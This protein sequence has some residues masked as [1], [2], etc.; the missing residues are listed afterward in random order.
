[1]EHQATDTSLTSSDAPSGGWYAL[2]GVLAAGVALAI[3]EFLSGLFFSAPSLVLALGEKAIDLA[4]GPVERW[5]IATF[6]TYDKLVLVVGIVVVTLI[7]GAI[8]GVVSRTK[9]AAAILGFVVFGLLGFA[10]ASAVPLSSTL[11][12]FVTAAAAA[13]TGIAA[14]SVLVRILQ[15]PQQDS[16]QTWDRSRRVFLGGSA[17]V[18]AVAASSAAL[19]RWLAERARVAVANR[20]EVT[21]PPPGTSAVAPTAA[22]MANT[23]NV[24]PFVTSNRDFYRID[25]ALSIPTV[26]LDTW[27]LSITGLVDRPFSLTYDQLLSLPMIERYITIACVSNRIGGDLIGNALWLGVPLRTLIEEASVQD[28]GTQL[29]GRAVD[30]FTV[31]FPTA[32]VFDGREAMVAVGMNGEPLPFEHGFPAR[33]IVSGLY[34]YVS[35]TKWLSE[36]ELAGWDDFDAYWIPRG[37]SKEGP[38]KTQSRIDTPRHGSTVTAGPN[39]IAGVAWAQNSGIMRVEVRVNDGPWMEADLPEEL[40]IDTWRQWSIDY[41]FEPG[42]SIIAVRA[43]DADGQ[44]Q[45]EEI[46]NVAPSGATGYHTI[47][48]GV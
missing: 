25:T 37:W 20:E 32:A 33:L 3:S 11:L 47:R 2:A 7:L 45:T 9:P 42:S 12:S 24:T 27:T 48:V 6:G 30:E 43:T 15:L 5:A 13:V 19:G 44:T 36:I 17:A 40:N 8:F 35:A 22:Q 18:L 16:S 28:E 4:P 38:I 34:G 1:M 39:A 23:A 29:I 10:A 46:T 26:E 31:G 41:E 21:L 14:L